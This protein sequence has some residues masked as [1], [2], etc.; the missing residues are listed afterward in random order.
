MPL[1]QPDRLLSIG[2]RDRYFRCA[3]MGF[4]QVKLPSGP[5]GVKSLFTRFYTGIALYSTPLS[6]P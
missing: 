1:E 3:E 2:R 5:E 6:R 4:I